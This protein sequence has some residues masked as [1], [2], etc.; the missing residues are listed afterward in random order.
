M[1]AEFSI[2]NSH[3]EWDELEEVIVGRGVPSELPALE[4]TFKL[5]FHDIIPEI[6]I[7]LKM[8]AVVN[9]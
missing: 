8:T 6:T 7:I 4:M 5:F 9:Q 2:V 1:A 3:N